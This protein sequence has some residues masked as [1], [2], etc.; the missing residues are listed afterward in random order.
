MAEMTTQD[1]VKTALRTTKSPLAWEPFYATLRK[2]VEQPEWRIFRANNCLFLINNNGDHTAKVYMFNADTAKDMVA[3]FKDFAIAMQKCGFT[4]VEFN[5]DRPALSRVIE[6]AGYRAQI[7]PGI[8]RI[9]DAQ[10]PAAKIKVV[11]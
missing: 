7:L 11:L 8:A 9:G 5:T 4:E 2:L 6:R 3:S 1:I 10:K